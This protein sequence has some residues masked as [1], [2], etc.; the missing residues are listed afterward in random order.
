MR[1]AS[2]GK[3]FFSDKAFF[4]T[5][6]F[7]AVPMV[8]QNLIVSSLNMVDTVMLGS[9]GDN[10]VAAVG[11]ANQYFFLFNLIMTGVAGGCS[12]FIS[13]F[14]GQRDTENIKKVMGIGIAGIF[15]LGAAFTLWALLGPE[16][17]ARLFSKDTPVIALCCGYLKI[18][19]LSY[20][21][22]GI[23]LLFSTALRSVGNAK[24]PMLISA[25]AIL[26]NVV[27]N[28]I[29]IFGHLGAPA[30]GVNGAALATIIARFVEVTLILILGLKHGSPLRGRLKIYLSASCSFTQKVVAAMVPVVLNEGCWGAGMILYAIAYGKI[31]TQAMAAVQICTT[32]Q[33]LFM[34]VCFGMAGAALVITGNEIG[35][36]K[37]EAAKR[38]SRIFAIVA[39]FIGVCLCLLL[40]LLAPAILTMFRSVSAGV[41]A[42]AILMLRIYAL[43]AP[44]RTFNCVLIIG[45]FRG[46]GDASFAL[47][48]EAVTMWCIGV[49]LA[50]LGALL[51]QLPIEQVILL[52]TMEEVVKFFPCL[53]RL[54]NNKWA[55]NLIQDI[56]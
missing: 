52:V 29:F 6:L 2:I 43:S 22:T 3:N 10:E 20:I 44:I 19:G 48:T 35:A 24:L 30:L 53:V 15:L 1:A 32:V 33:N 39:V 46:G 9:V 41:T 12:I 55:K 16:S 4:H 56:S 36:G 34:V 37:E 5:L 51:W 27:L 50:F 45:V 42:S 17:I 13:Q 47:K 54:R 7:L 28:Y 25:L 38:H 18:T 23:T 26:I 21:A 8:I 31:G 40:Y 11:I 49:P 14:W